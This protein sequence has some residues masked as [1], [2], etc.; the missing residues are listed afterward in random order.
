MRIRPIMKQV[1]K[2][3]SIHTG[4][5]ALGFFGLLVLSGCN[6]VQGVG[7]DVEEAGDAIE[8]EAQEYS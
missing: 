7:E 2:K 8:E 4:I 5:A 6:T 3:Y 1:F